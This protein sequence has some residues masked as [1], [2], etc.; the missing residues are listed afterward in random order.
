[1]KKKNRNE[2]EQNM[3]IDSKIRMFVNDFGG[4]CDRVIRR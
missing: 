4:L 1:M 2:E 3:C